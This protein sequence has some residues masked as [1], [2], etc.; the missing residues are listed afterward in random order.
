MDDNTCEE[1]FFDLQELFE[2]T[3]RVRGPK[4]TVAADGSILAF[5]QGGCLM[6]RSE[7]SGE[8]WGSVQEL[9]AGEC[10]AVVDRHNGDVLLVRAK[11]SALWRSRDHGKTWQHETITITPNDAGHGGS[12]N[13]PANGTASDPGIT[14]QQL[15]SGR[16]CLRVHRTHLRF[17]GG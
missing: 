13:S 11:D 5:L 4:I 9:E 1:P 6:R 8:T 7:D 17:G 15:P 10:N 14:L 2:I 16:V 3:P 12:E